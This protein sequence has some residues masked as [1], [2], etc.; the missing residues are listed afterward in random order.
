MNIQPKLIQDCIDRDRRAEYTLYKTVYSYLMSICI[1]YVGQQE[2]ARE[3]LNL[4]YFKILTH[5][6]EYNQNTPFKP[7]IRRIMINTLIDEYRKE[8][9]THQQLTFIE[10]YTETENL[11]EINKAIEKMDVAQIYALINLLPPT[12]REVFN[13]FVFDDFSHKEIAIALG[14]SEGTS[15]WHLNQARQKLKAGL[16]YKELITSFHHE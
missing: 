8:K 9:R 5:L 2:L 7:W 3:V 6:S 13:L 12:S 16:E 11:Y 4:G 10:N 15:K 14:I 1:R